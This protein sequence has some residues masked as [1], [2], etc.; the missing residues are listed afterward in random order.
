V[1]PRQS[2]LRAKLR[3]QKPIAQAKEY[4][5]IGRTHHDRI[6]SSYAAKQRADE[7]TEQNCNPLLVCILDELN[8]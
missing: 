1:D 5:I 4:Y 6:I 2:K 3:K 8:I 7:V